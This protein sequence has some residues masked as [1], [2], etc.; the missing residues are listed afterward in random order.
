[1]NSICFFLGVRFLSAFYVIMTHCWL[2]KSSKAIM[3]PSLL[4]VVVSSLLIIDNIHCETVQCTSSTNANCSCT[5]PG[6]CQIICNQ[7][8]SCNGADGDVMCYPGYPC[9]ISCGGQS[10]CQDLQFRSNS[11]TKITL[12]CSAKD[13]CKGS[14]GYLD[15]GGNRLFH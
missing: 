13:A 14:N 12:T 10:S 11:A 1:M 2:A 8:D 9:E 6:L 4:T 3:T 15:C 7:I 5:E